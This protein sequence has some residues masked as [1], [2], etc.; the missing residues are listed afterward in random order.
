LGTTAGGAIIS[1]AIRASAEAAAAPLDRIGAL[2]LDTTRLGAA[3]ELQRQ[4][5]LVVQAHPVGTVSSHETGRRSGGR[6]VLHYVQRLQ[7][8]ATLKGRPP[9]ELRLVLPGVH[10]LPAAKDPANEAYPGPLADGE[11]YVLFLRPT[12]VPGMYTSVGGWQGIYPLDDEGRT[13]ALAGAGFQ[14]FGGLTP[15]ELKARLHAAP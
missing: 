5:L 9:T 14:Q 12:G 13:I 2:R 4:A 3:T 8:V 11:A 10:P 1:D 15:D 6:D 7:P